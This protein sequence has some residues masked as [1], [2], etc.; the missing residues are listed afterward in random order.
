MKHLAETIDTYI[1][2]TSFISDN[3]EIQKVVKCVRDFDIKRQNL[4]SCFDKSNSGLYDLS[5]DTEVL[6]CTSQDPNSQLETKTFKQ[7]KELSVRI[8]SK[9]H[10]YVKT[11]VFMELC[12]PQLTIIQCMLRLLNFFA[13]N[14]E[15]FSNYSLNS[16]P[17]KKTIFL[18][19]G[20]VSCAMRQLPSIKYECLLFI[21]LIISVQNFMRNALLKVS[22]MTVFTQCSNA[23]MQNTNI[24]SKKLVTKIPVSGKQ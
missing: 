14:F 13:D 23:L 18:L 20:R 4:Q 10:M 7:K 6:P 5:D 3:E 24:C 1:M 17:K 16:S 2:Y 8:V 12:E 22:S 9:T 15:Q 21:S 19:L 11:P